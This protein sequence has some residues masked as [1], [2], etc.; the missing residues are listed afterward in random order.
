[1]SA[2]A[3]V[4]L[5]RGEKVRLASDMPEVIGAA[6]A[7]WGRDSLMKR[8]L[9]E[10]P[11]ALWSCK[12]IQGFHERLVE[13]GPGNA[14]LFYIHSLEGDRLV[15]QVRLWLTAPQHGEAWVGMAIGDRRDWDR[16]Y[17]S[18]A[19]RLALRYAFD[20]LN[21]QRVTLGVFDYNQRGI[22]VYEKLGFRL[23]GVERAAV[24]REGRRFDQLV[25][26][27][28]RSEWEALQTAVPA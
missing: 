4:D 17:G 10:E 25:M 11:A 5:F 14:F 8:L 22:H 1:M 9:N 19:L 24:Q 6:W 3:P 20:E 18:D 13:S 2:M 23:E 28:L 26:G 7:R 16:G 15:G 12:S 27:I 21:L